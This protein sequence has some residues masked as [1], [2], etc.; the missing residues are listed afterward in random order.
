MSNEKQPEKP[1]LFQPGESG[2]PLGRPRGSRNRLSEKFLLDLRDTWSRHGM[3]IL[4]K[5]AT[6]Q[7]AKLLAAMVQLMPRDVLISIN[8]NRPIIEYSNE[9][10]IAIIRGSE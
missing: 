8:D 2:N 10:L 6:E 3:Q 4:E 7:P 1:W 5:V 9:E